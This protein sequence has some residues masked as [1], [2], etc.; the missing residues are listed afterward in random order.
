[1]WRLNEDWIRFMYQADGV[2]AGPRYEEPEDDDDDEVEIVPPGQ[3]FEDESDE[4]D[5]SKVTM[6]REELEALRQQANSTE[7]LRQSF[8]QMAERMAEGSQQ[9]H[10]AAN[11]QAPQQPGE[12][13]EQFQARIEKELF[14]SGKTTK[15]L[16][17]VFSRY[18]APVINQQN[19]RLS[20]ANKRLMQLD[21]ER[22]DKFKKYQSE[23]EKFVSSLPQ[24]Q[25]NHP[26]VW[27]YAYNEVVMKRHSQDEIEALVQQ[28]V[29]QELSKHQG[30]QDGQGQGSA[31]PSPPKRTP[32][33]GS[34]APKKKKRR[35]Q[36]TEQDVAKAN[37][38]GIEIEKYMKHV[39][40]VK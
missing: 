5:D 31:S 10:Q 36:P 29:E 22:G 15:A 38:L 24:E 14:E 17:E 11:Q 23:I 19:Q 8:N 39:K 18:G 2:E 3:P 32:S 35:I 37:E 21:P 34:V 1:M 6:S 7:Q 13:D 26:D 16:Q 28:R 20:Q 27:E 4:E 12:S 9:Q 33:P 30:L 40:G 25:Q